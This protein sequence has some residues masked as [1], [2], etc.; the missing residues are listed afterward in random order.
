MMMATQHE[1]DDHQ[2]ERGPAQRLGIQRVSEKVLAINSAVDAEGQDRC[3]EQA[4]DDAADDAAP[5]GDEAEPRDS[6]SS[7][8]CTP[9]H[10]GSWASFYRIIRLRA[11]GRTTTIGEP[12][13]PRSAAQV[14]QASTSLYARPGSE[15]PLNNTCEAGSIC[16]SRTE[17]GHGGRG[18][19]ADG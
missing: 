12:P 5:A 9:R 16:D 15:N 7:D 10:A 13:A 4:E 8:V 3:G 18:R 17:C 1:R 6:R 2:G 11:C 14:D 19:A